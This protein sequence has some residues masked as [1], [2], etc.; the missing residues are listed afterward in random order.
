MEDRNMPEYEAP[1][2]VTYTDEEVPRDWGRRRR[3]AAPPTH[4]R[5]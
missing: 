3:Y 5:K 2:V 1:Q 4:R